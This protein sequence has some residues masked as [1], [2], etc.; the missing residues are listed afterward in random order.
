MKRRRNGD[1]KNIESIISNGVEIKGELNSKGSIRIDGFLDGKM[2]V[3]GDIIL[4]D[5]GH[6]KGEVKAEN[7]IIAGK[8]EGNVSVKKRLEIATTGNLSGDVSCSILTIEEGGIL[9]GNSSMDKIGGKPD[10]IKEVVKK[11]R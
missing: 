6:I 5:K 9:N 1:Y 7:I 2:N 8:I 4:G 11:K 10:A 3:Q